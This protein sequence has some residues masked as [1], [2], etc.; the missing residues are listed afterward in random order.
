MSYKVFELWGPQEPYIL[1]KNNKYKNKTLTHI[2][3][4]MDPT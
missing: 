2:D 1:Q 4:S 3:P